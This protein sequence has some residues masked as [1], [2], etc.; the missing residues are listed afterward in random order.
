MVP[1]AADQGEPKL[2]RV[3]TLDRA[4]RSHRNIRIR[5]PPV[6]LRRAG[7]VDRDLCFRFVRGSGPRILEAL[8]QFG[9]EIAPRSTPRTDYFAK[10]GQSY[11][12]PAPQ[13]QSPSGTARPLARPPSIED[14][15]AFIVAADRGSRT[16]TRITDDV[17]LATR[18]ADRAVYFETTRTDGRWLHRS[19]LGK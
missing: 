13:R 15:K 2:R 9:R 11:S 3:V 14:V 8:G 5:V 7:S 12:M 17:Q 10:C 16:V 19:Y 18:D 4:M 1:Q 6:R